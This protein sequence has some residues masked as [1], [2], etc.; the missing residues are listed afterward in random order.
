MSQKKILE[1]LKRFFQDYK[2]FMT[3]L[4]IKGY[5]NRSEL[6][7]TLHLVNGATFQLK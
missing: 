1:R 5:A 3:D 4:L 2:N 7:T 6:K